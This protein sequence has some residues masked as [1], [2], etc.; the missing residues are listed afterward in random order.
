MQSFTTER[1]LIRPLVEQDNAMYVGLYTDANIMK[2][3]GEPLSGE[4]AEKA[5]AR[6]I[7]AMQKPKPKTMTWA[8]VTLADKKNIGIQALSWQRPTFNHKQ[9]TPNN[10]QAD[11]GIMLTSASQGQRIPAESLNML[12][13]YAFNELGLDMITAYHSK[14]NLKSQ[15]VFDKLGFIFDAKVQPENTNDCYRYFDKEKWLYP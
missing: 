11:I 2:Y 5:F 14:I 3:I 7:K 10:N 15:R 4:A 13:A 8:I 12:I 1:L 6:T 9:I